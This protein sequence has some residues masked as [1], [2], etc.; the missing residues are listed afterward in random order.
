MSPPCQ[1]DECWRL[2]E[3]QS[4]PLLHKGDIVHLM[5]RL[6][7]ESLQKGNWGSKSHWSLLRKAC[8][9]H[10]KKISYQNHLFV[11]AFLS[12]VKADMRSG[13]ETSDLFS[14]TKQ[15]ETRW[16]I[17][18]CPVSQWKDA[19]TNKMCIVQQTKRWK[20]TKDPCT[21]FF[22][23]SKDLTKLFQNFPFEKVLKNLIFSGECISRFGP[24]PVCAATG[25]WWDHAD[26]APCLP[27][28]NPPPL[29]TNQALHFG[30]PP[31]P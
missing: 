3:Y 29:F 19:N 22:L 30:G 7:E 21:V 24:R 31:L 15:N 6:H 10:S 2:R 25:S 4:F 12:V 11:F 14:E 1:A 9:V 20:K 18:I 26:L 8:A 5:R 28:A 27:A 13:M 17:C 16:G 23:S